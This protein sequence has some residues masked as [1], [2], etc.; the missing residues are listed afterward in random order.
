MSS[1]I[2]KFSRYTAASLLLVSVLCGCKKGFF[3]LEDQNG[4]NDEGI[5][6]NE[7]PA[8]LFLN[9]TYDLIMP[10]WPSVGGIHNTSDE[11]N[12]ANTDF[13]Y[14]TL[15]ENSVTDI[16]TGNGAGTNRYF[17]IR[18]CNVAIDG[19]N[20][21]T[22]SDDVKI[23]L[24]GQFFFLRAYVYFRLVSLYGGVPLILH[25][26]DLNGEDLNVPRSKTSEC[27]AAIVNDLDS[28]AAYLPA[29]WGSSDVGRITKNAALAY[30]GKV[31]LYWASPQFNPANLA[32]RWED[33]Y[34]ACKQAYDTCVARGQ[35]L[36]SNYANIFV[37]EDHKEILLV[38]KLDA[39]SLS[40]ARGTN[41]EYITRPYSES[42]GGGSN[43]PTWNL[44]QAYTMNNGLPISHT[45]SGY[46]AVLFW[47]N[48][49]PRFEMSIAYNGGAWPLSG[50]ALRKQWN[51]TGVVD[52]TANTII[53][54]FYCKRITNPTLQAS[55]A[56]YNSNTGGG[57]GMDW[58]EMRFA[59]VV[60]NLA[61]C[62]NETGRLTEAKDMVRLIRKRAGIVQG[63]YDYGLSVATNT[64]EM[65]SLI[66]SERQVEFAMEGKRYW[67]LRRTRNY[68]LITSRFGVKWA[69]KPPYYA[70]T[71]RSGALA[72][73]IFLDKAD[74]NGVKPRDT[75]NLNNKSVYQAMF[76]PS[77]TTIEGSNV[78]SIPEK[79]YFYALPNFFNQATYTMEQ[80]KG[81]TGGTFDP[82]Q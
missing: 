23:K 48:R 54:G 16:G 42:G 68:G 13:L 64:A 58:I 10:N 65:R 29:S 47:R 34:T 80:T 37:T 14:G 31:L 8:S 38:R 20:N 19:I 33:A 26:Q 67:D 6:N 43:Q 44:V 22:L 51:Y 72:T 62:A 55:Q 57:S 17:D 45:S 61:E 75:A 69:P 49:D 60:M 70:G 12:N 63:T 1:F 3:D 18:R 39:V 35:I 15:L 21:S 50:K 4:I 11:L 77:I 9:K 79:Y 74:A 81:W 78:V 56:Q 66:L 41:T 53:T 24:K 32:N 25:A 46:D 59:E 76:T 30:K 52:E 40:P 73:D 71:T 36:L 27:I 5:W 28:A 2:N 7:G 82:L